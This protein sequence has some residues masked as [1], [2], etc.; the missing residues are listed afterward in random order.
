MARTAASRSADDSAELKYVVYVSRHGVRSPTAKVSQYSLYST[1]P[2]PTWDVP[3]GY[4]TKHGYGLMK[5]FG[6]YDRMQLAHEGLL[7]ARGCGDA[8]SV[9]FYADSSQRTRET[10]KALAEGLFPGCNISVQSLPEGT[11]DPLFHP[12]PVKLNSADADLAVASIAGR[13]G[14]KPENLTDAYRNQLAAFDDVLSTCSNAAEDISPKRFSLMEIPSSLSAGKVDR[15]VDLRG[16]LNTAATL[17]ENLLLEYT[18]GMDASNVGWGCVDGSRLRSLIDLHTAA[19]DFTQRTPAIAK[20]QASNLLDHINRSLEQAMTHHS[21]A[22]A[23]GK[24]SDRALFL[25]GHDT[26]LSNVSG[27]LN[28]NW[29]ADGRRDDT[30]PGSAFIFELWKDRK[31]ESYSV[32]IYFTTQTLEQMRSSTLLTLSNPP[33]RTP[34]FIPGCSRAD[35]SCTWSAFSQ[36]LHQAVDS[37]Y[38]Y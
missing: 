11:N 4:L 25:I 1:A 22:G 5:I 6:G 32:R 3:P 30:P 36:T 19:S 20:I 14:D 31:T 23:Q 10:G 12:A 8:N 33:I 27:L 29:I 28:L 9:T 34:I 17:S 24:P 18:E 7:S 38:V 16:P 21:I 13:I 26:N 37:R 15:L 35:Y 2:W